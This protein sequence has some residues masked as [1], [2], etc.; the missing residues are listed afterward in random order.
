MNLIYNEDSCTVKVG[1]AVALGE[2]DEE[3]EVESIEK[4]HS[5][6]STGRVYLKRCGTDFV[7]GFFPS[8]IGASWD[9]RPDRGPVPRETS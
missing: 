9:D 1:D 2:D 8:V 6:A 7:Q 5:P 3:W 4:P